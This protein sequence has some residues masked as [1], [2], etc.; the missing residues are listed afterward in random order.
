M[1]RDRQESVYW[2]D[3]P[4]G[5]MPSDAVDVY[6]TPCCGDYGAMRDR[7][8]LAAVDPL[9]GP[10]EAVLAPRA[11]RDGFGQRWRIV[12]PHDLAVIRSANTWRRM[13]DGQLADYRAH[14]SGPLEQGMAF[15]REAPVV[16][17]ARRR[18]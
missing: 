1:P 18:G 17:V 7:I 4:A 8:P 6:P 15:L 16:S 10:P 12:P 9:D 3:Y 5:L 11:G 13:D 2:R 14:L